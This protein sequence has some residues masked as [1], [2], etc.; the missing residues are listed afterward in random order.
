M[1]TTYT[2]NRGYA[3][4][5]TGDDPNLWGPVINNNFSTIDANISGKLSITT[6]G[7]TTT[8]TSTQAEN[9]FFDIVGTLTANA[10]IVFPAQQTFFM[11]QN[12]TSGSFTVTFVCAGG[13]TSVI[14]P[15][16]NTGLFYCDNTNMKLMADVAPA[17]AP[18]PVFGNAVATAVGTTVTA[19]TSSFTMPFNGKITIDGNASGNVAFSSLTLG[20]TANDS[21]VSG[22]TRSGYVTGL[23]VATGYFSVGAG[24]TVVISMTANYTSSG[25]IGCGFKYEMVP[26]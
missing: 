17:A 8:L 14:L 24:E 9:V 18:N 2:P 5:G 11:G 16:G 3:L 13:G 4:P 21:A 1:T 6:T 26:Q 23:G 15:Q 12:F 19:S 20:V 7:G 22:F 10:T 25:V